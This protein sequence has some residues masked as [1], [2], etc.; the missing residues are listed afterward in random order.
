[1]IWVRKSEGFRSGIDGRHNE[2]VALAGPNQSQLQW[3]WHN[4]DWG[5]QDALASPVPVPGEINLGTAANPVWHF[6]DDAVT[7]RVLAGVNSAGTLGILQE[8]TSGPL[9]YTF[10]PGAVPIDGPP[11]IQNFSEDLSFRLYT[12]PEPSTIV[13]LG[14]GAFGFGTTLWRR[15]RTRDG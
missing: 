11:G 8:V 1:M 2:I 6:Q 7:G 14:L 10:T 9:N 15:R 4:R 5:I 12:V 13:L 3:G